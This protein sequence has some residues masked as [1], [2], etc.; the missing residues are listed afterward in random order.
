M[1]V[2]NFPTEQPHVTSVNCRSRLPI[3]VTKYS[4]V[5]LNTGFVYQSVVQLQSGMFAYKNKGCNFW[6]ECKLLQ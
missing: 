3:T 4:F 6:A 5:L 2:E 1:W